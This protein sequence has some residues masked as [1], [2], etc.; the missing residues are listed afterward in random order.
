MTR[1]ILFIDRDGTLIEEPADNQVD[2]IPKL[3]FMSGVITALLEFK[4]AGYHLVIISNQDGLG[5]A[6]FPEK[7]FREAHEFMLRVFQSQG[8]EFESIRICPH[9][10]NDRCNC[11]KPEIGLVLD[12]LARQEIDINHSYVIGDRATDLQLAEKMG[13]PGIQ[14]GV[15]DN[16]TWTDIVHKILYSDRKAFC[17]RQTNETVIVLGINLDQPDPIVINTGIGFFD[18]MLEQ[19]AKHGGFSLSLD[20]KGDLHIDE[21]HTIEDIGIAIGQALHQALGDKRG[22]ARYGFLL[23]MDESLA[24]VALDLSGRSYYEFNGQFPREQI[25]G[26]PTE[27]VSHFFRS[28]GE[29]LK[30]TLNIAV[31]GE[32]THH[33]IESVFKAVGRT[34]RQA[35]TRTNFDLPSTKGVL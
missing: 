1:K 28:L 20:M 29:N 31:K 5:S 34:L 14:I 8:I 33:M 27:L 6:S 19:L 2:S 23:P 10:V 26:F 13:I 30:A 11:R 24:Q 9:K 12:Y 18:H 16:K 25:G 15:G 35:M 22:V 7:S 3:H 21:H 17:T 32:N 4:K